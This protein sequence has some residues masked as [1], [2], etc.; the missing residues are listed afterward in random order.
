M[1]ASIPAPRIRT[2]IYLLAVGIVLVAL[3]LWYDGLNAAELGVF[4]RPSAW[5]ISFTLN[6]QPVV[7]PEGIALPEI[8]ALLDRSCAGGHTFLLMLGVAAFA[9]RDHRPRSV[10]RLVALTISVIIGAYL[11]TVSG[12]ASRVIL[13]V[14]AERFDPNTVGA[15]HTLIGAFIQMSLLLTTYVVLHHYART[16]HRPA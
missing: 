14:I 8:G 13:T 7:R 9:L 15:A 6:I 10:T 4:L 1:L 5:L 2:G 12:N 16:R 3:R 11:L